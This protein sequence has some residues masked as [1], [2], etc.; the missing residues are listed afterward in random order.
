MKIGVDI[1]GVII[2]FEKELKVYAELFTFVELNRNI[3]T[4]KSEFLVQFRHGWSDKEFEDF[5][6]KYFMEIS[7]RTDFLPGAVDVLKKLKK[8]GHELIIISARGTI[9]EE[10]KDVALERFKKVGLKFDNYYWNQQDKVKVALNEKLDFMIDDN[11]DHCKKLVDA[12]IKSLFFRDSGTRELSE[13]DS[14]FE[15]NNWGEIYKI[16]TLESKKNG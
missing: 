14:L 10:M 8:D 7:R 9:I 6:K 5:G 4:D 15:V 12:G 1:D 16:I 13:S 3:P 2:N 11:P